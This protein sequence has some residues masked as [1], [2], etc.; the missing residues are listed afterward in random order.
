[1][2][3]FSLQVRYFNVIS[4]II[5]HA[6]KNYLLTSYLSHYIVIVNA[7]EACGF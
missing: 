4:Q 3:Y 6:L 1:M 2:E 7:F 5:F